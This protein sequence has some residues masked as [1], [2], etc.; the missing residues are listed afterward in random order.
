VNPE[1]L[2]RLVAA[3]ARPKLTLADFGFLLDKHPLEV[4]CAGQLSREP[5]LSWPVL[6][7]RSPV[8]RR[9]AAK[10]LFHP[11]NRPAQNLRLRIRFEQDA[12]ARMTPYWRRLCFPFESLVPSY[13]TALGSSSDRPTALAELMGVIV[14]QG[15]RRPVVKVQKLVFAAGTPYHTVFEPGSSAGE[16]VMAPAVA[17]TLR[18]VLVDV[19]E[20]GTAR[21]VAGAFGD[22]DGSPI[23]I[24]GKTGS[25]DN[26]VE[27]VD[28]QGERISSR[29][30]NRTATFVFF[31][32]ERYFG[33]LTAYV[34]GVE[35]GDFE[36]TSALPVS[37]LKLLS[38]ALNLYP[39]TIDSGRKPDSVALSR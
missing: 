1:E 19:V 8:A 24:G 38:P 15:V 27:R 29:P 6:L 33:T 26:R 10:W 13:A 12:F 36:F 34:A 17:Q 16:R 18:N 35:A 30:I 39:R 5:S 32:G 25:G 14:N 20:R 2:E 4:W 28:H 9:M 31:I 23:P 3:Y 22:L 21:R 11:R 37:V 7:G